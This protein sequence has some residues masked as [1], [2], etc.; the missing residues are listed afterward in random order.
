MD[1]PVTPWEATLGD[2]VPIKIFHGNASLTIPP[3]TQCGQKLRL[4]GRGLPRRANKDAGDLLV[5]I[6]V[7]V[8]KKMT[9][10]EKELFKEL[11]QH[12]HFNPRK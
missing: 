1:L 2:K 12:S 10:K 9:A 6:R 4:K 11:A 3:G 7:R 5:N 8:P